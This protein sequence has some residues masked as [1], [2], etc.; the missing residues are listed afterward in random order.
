MKIFKI[1]TFVV[2]TLGLIA[3]NYILTYSGAGGALYVLSPYFIMAC[4]TA[5]IQYKTTDAAANISLFIAACFV[6][7]LKATAYYQAVFHPAS[8]TD[9]LIFLTMP[10]FSIAIFLGAYAISKA[11]IS[12]KRKKH[13]ESLVGKKTITVGLQLLAVFVFFGVCNVVRSIDFRKN[14]FSWEETETTNGDVFRARKLGVYVKDLHYKVD[15]FNETMDFYPFIEKV[16]KYNRTGEE[17]ETFKDIEFPYAVTYQPEPVKGAIVLLRKGQES[18]VRERRYV[19]REPKL[20]DTIFLK[21]IRA[22]VVIGHIKI[23][24]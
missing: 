12:T 20:K 9:G 14:E 2:I 4:I 18:K 6:C 22:G 13:E 1:L 10:L 23:W 7:A 15:S 17:I 11:L 8:S 3:T 16:F 19:L 24:D 5:L 21:M